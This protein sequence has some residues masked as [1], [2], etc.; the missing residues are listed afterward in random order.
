MYKSWTYVEKNR[1][2]DTWPILFLF[3]PENPSKI[4]TGEIKI[5]Q[6]H[7]MCIKRKVPKYYEFFLI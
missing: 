2:F 4:R 3:V 6:F 7:D 5:L 1:F